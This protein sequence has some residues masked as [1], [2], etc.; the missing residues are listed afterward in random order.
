MLAV[1]ATGRT[2]GLV[3]DIGTHQSTVVP[4]CE[5]VPLL[6]AACIIPLGAKAICNSLRNALFEHATVRL[7]IKLAYS[8]D[9][10]E[11]SS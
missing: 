4:V 7:F 6:R 1:T 3:I 2:N 5:S 8:Y 9:V 11:I 10:G